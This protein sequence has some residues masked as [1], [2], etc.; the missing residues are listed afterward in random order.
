ML[1]FIGS[2][3]ILYR[4]SLIGQNSYMLDDE[5]NIIMVRLYRSSLCFI[6]NCDSYSSHNYSL[7]SEQYQLLL[8]VPLMPLILRNGHCICIY[9]SSFDCLLHFLGRMWSVKYTGWI[10]LISQ[11]YIDHYNSILLHLY[12]NLEGL[13]GRKLFMNI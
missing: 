5:E 8:K 4:S 1:F 6:K 13:L 2:N 3:L 9:H 7:E 12:Q 11:Y 10:I